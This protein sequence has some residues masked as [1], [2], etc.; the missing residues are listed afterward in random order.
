[1]DRDPREQQEDIN[2]EEVEV[3]EE[4]TDENQKGNREA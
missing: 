1:M 3:V 2:N 4:E